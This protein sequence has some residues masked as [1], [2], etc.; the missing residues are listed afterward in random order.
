MKEN[1]SGKYEIVPLLRHCG[2]GD[3]VN[4]WLYFSSNAKFFGCFFSLGGSMANFQIFLI[5]FSVSPLVYWVLFPWAVTEKVDFLNGW[6]LD[7]LDLFQ[8]SASSL[9]GARRSRKRLIS[10]M[11]VVGAK[12]GA[13]GGSLQGKS[14]VI[15]HIFFFCFLSI[16]F[17]FLCFLSMFFFFILNIFKNGYKI[18]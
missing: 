3:K 1:N 7:F 18:N 5:C 11:A 4:W 8:L 13:F 9:L 14:Y 2:G 6:F 16:F 15:Y 17:L 10:W 12:P